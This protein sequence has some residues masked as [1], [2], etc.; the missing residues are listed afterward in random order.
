MFMNMISFSCKDQ[1]AHAS[2]NCFQF[3]ACNKHN[4]LNKTLERTLKNTLRK[5]T[6][7]ICR[8]GPFKHVWVSIYCMQK[9]NRRTI[10][11]VAKQ[12]D[13]RRRCTKVY[14]SWGHYKPIVLDMGHKH[15]KVNILCSLSYKMTSNYKSTLIYWKHKYQFIQW[16]LWGYIFFI[17]LK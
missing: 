8:K 13:Y 1:I 11:K 2:S 10:G 5:W 14:N 7:G 9:I 3:G 16:L 17:L 6:Q 4:H 15:G 12:F